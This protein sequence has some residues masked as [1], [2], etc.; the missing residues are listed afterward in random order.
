MT[1]TEVLKLMQYVA[2]QM[3]KDKPSVNNIYVRVPEDSKCESFLADL[4]DC[5]DKKLFLQSNVVFHYPAKGM[6]PDS[7]ADAS[8]SYVPDLHCM[9]ADNT[10]V[11]QV[12]WHCAADSIEV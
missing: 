7:L 5:E 1:T 8:G 10:K 6:F 4:R 3:V 11:F 2:L 12:D 9:K